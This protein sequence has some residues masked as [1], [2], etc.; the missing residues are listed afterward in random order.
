VLL[1]GCLTVSSSEEDMMSLELSSYGLGN[2]QER[3]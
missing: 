1:P 2:A 3:N